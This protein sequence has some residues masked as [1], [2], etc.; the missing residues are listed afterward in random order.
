MSVDENGF[1]SILHLFNQLGFDPVALIGTLGPF[2]TKVF[3]LP[4]L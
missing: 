2:D 4:F 1:Y 3:S